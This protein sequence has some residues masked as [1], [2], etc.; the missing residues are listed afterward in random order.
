MSSTSL[1]NFN[2]VESYATLDN[3]N[4]S[5]G[6]QLRDGTNS[7]RYSRYVIEHFDEE[8]LYFADDADYFCGDGEETHLV[9]KLEDE[10]REAGFGVVRKHQCKKVI[11]LL[12]GKSFACFRKRY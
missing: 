8:K 4:S 9:G 5:F 2:S 10:Q 11:E 12:R 6:N 3:S 1:S 7:D